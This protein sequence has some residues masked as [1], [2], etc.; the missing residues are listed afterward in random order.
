MNRRII[1]FIHTKTNVP[2]L[3]TVSPTFPLPYEA[4][5]H[6]PDLLSQL[7]SWLVS[8]F[9]I[10]QS[11][12]KFKYS[13]LIEKKKRLSKKGTETGRATCLVKNVPSEKISNTILSV[14]CGP[15]WKQCNSKV[16]ADN[17]SLDLLSCY[18]RTPKS[19][20]SC[21]T[22]HSRGSHYWPEAVVDRWCLW[23]RL[24]SQLFKTK[25]ISRH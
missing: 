20:C 8:W 4:E 3:S 17:V 13:Y 15:L 2:L 12:C 18:H 7:C 22:W 23:L 1:S 6:R 25:S 5:I 9:W 24:L 16:L 10:S 11:L 21:T 14:L 19:H